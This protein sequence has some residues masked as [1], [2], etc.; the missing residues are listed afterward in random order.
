[1]KHIIIGQNF[2]V[3]KI[4]CA[5]EDQGPS[6]QGCKAEE[7]FQCCRYGL[8]G[9]DKSSYSPIFPVVIHS[10]TEGAASLIKHII[11]DQ[12]FE[13]KKVVRATEDE[14]PSEQMRG[15][16]ISDWRTYYND[17]TDEHECV[18]LER[19]YWKKRVQRFETDSREANIQLD[20]AERGTAPLIR[21]S[22]LRHSEAAPAY[23]SANQ[24][25][26][27]GMQAA[28]L[29][30]RGEKVDEVLP[31]FCDQSQE[32]AGNIQAS[33]LHP[34]DEKHDG[35]LFGYWR[36]F[37]PRSIKTNAPSEDALFADY[38]SEP[39]PGPNPKSV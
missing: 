5:T 18:V 29:K 25:N 33:R 37:A 14:D 26:T 1:M 11:I 36:E 19:D 16:S 15:F 2:E 34:N 35:N 31:S 12:D 7:S 24:S 17:F 23:L 10:S 30:I 32:P 28:A 8:S 6:E 20:A 38:E 13:I 22:A 27:A 21:S 4:V 9:L 3:K 39:S